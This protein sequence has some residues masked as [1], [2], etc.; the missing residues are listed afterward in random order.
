MEREG[1]WPPFDPDVVISRTV[2]LPADQG[3]DYRTFVDQVLRECAAAL[4]LP[5]E[6]LLADPPLRPIPRHRSLVPRGS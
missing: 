5:A 6:L 3:I 2:P 1:T 4:V